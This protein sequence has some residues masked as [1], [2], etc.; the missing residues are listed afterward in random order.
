MSH[1]RRRVIMVATSCDRFQ[2]DDRRKSMLKDTAILTGCKVISKGLGLK[3]ENVTSNNP[4]QSRN[5]NKGAVRFACSL[6]IKRPF[7][8]LFVRLL[9]DKFGDSHHEHIHSEREEP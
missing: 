3:I 7:R 4:D 5:Q 2:S 1:V 9:Y 6:T 8:I